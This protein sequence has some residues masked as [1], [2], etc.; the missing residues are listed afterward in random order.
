MFWPISWASCLSQAV[1][2]V[3]PISA[4]CLFRL[5]GR[6]EPLVE[7]LVRVMLL[8]RSSG[9]LW[10]G[11]RR[12][13]DFS[14]FSNCSLFFVRRIY[15]CAAGSGLVSTETASKVKKF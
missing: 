3:D 1:C 14:Q 9:V 2:E 15:G 5:I 4:E 7:R 12:G 10:R 13:L 8:A 11:K 6:E